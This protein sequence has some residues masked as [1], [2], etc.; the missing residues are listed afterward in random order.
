M[1]TL[2]RNLKVAVL[3]ESLH[4]NPFARKKRWPLFA[5]LEETLRRTRLVVYVSNALTR[6]FV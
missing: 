4:F 1:E 5:R 3:S 6:A 2:L